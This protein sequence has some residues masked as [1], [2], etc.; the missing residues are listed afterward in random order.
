[1]LIAI[2]KYQ[3]PLDEVDVYRTKYHEYL[4]SFFAAEKLLIS[5][6]QNDNS[7]GVIVAKNISK[8]E[9][10]KILAND[11]FVKASV[12]Q[13]AIYEFTASF[14]DALLSGLS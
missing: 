7:G 2:S 13:Y 11:P 1:M 3:K 5:G 6:R 10:E 4:K 12:T 9:F 14:C 8:D